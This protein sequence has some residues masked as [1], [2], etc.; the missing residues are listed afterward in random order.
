M[1]RP[2]DYEMIS[3]AIDNELSAAEKQELE[4]HLNSCSQCRNYYAACRRTSQEVRNSIFG[5]GNTQKILA[6][7]ELPTAMIKAIAAKQ[8][9]RENVTTISRDSLP[10]AA[11][12]TARFIGIPSEVLQENGY[13][14]H[15]AIVAEKRRNGY[16][17]YLQSN[18]TMTLRATFLRDDK[19]LYKIE[20]NNHIPHDNNL[21]FVDIEGWTHLQLERLS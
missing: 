1:S 11:G 2:C 16:I 15:T 4:K 5:D 18:I 10:A 12:S 20:I 8:K 19:E 3:R 21:I 9:L 13:P 6:D 7:L 14:T 17:V